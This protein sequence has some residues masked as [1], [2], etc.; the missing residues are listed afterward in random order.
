MVMVEILDRAAEL[1]RARLTT[2]H[3]RLHSNSA[4]N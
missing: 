1:S 4:R 2:K 3:N